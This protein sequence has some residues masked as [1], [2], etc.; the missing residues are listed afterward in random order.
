VEIE[1]MVKD[2]EGHGFRNQNNRY[3]FYGAME[4]FLE[5]YLK[6]KQP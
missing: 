1:Y 2:N 6:A 4:E 3:D 5:K